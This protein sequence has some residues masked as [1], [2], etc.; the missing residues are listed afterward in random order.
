MGIGKKV[1]K[2][3]LTVGLMF[4]GGTRAYSASEPIAIAPK[5]KV[6]KVPDDVK[7]AIIDLYGGTKWKD[8]RLSEFLK[9]DTGYV[10][11]QYWKKFSEG[12]SEKL[13]VIGSI[14]DTKEPITDYHAYAP[15]MGGAIFRKLNSKWIVES[16]NRIIGWGGGFG[17]VGQ[18]DVVQV[19]RDKHGVSIREWDMHQGYEYIGTRI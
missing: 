19:G 13:L 17:D 10:N 7:T 1:L 6:F 3:I 16:E 4:A 11:L 5:A 12:G 9:V 15:L 2:I 14:A 8:K 18:I